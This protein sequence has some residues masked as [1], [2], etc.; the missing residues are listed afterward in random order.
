MKLQILGKPHPDL[1]A[2]S[3]TESDEYNGRTMRH[4]RRIKVF[5]HSQII[6]YVEDIGEPTGTGFVIPGGITTSSGHHES[7]HTVGELID[8]AENYKLTKVD[9]KAIS[10]D[11]FNRRQSASKGRNIY[12]RY[13][14][15][16]RR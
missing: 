2:W 11:E 6:E 1:P 16:E 10:D 13:R 3:Y 15:Y 8:V 5:E 4:M 12:G 7:E 9:W 14:R